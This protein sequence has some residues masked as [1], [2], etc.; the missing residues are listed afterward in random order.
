MTNGLEGLTSDKYSENM[1][2][3]RR[4]FA[5]V[6]TICVVHSQFL[7]NSE[8]QTRRVFDFL[9]LPQSGYRPSPESTKP[10][11]QQSSIERVLAAQGGNQSEMASAVREHMAKLDEF[12]A[13]EC[14]FAL[15]MCDEINAVN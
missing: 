8:Q 13:G 10:Y 5:D 3:W 4:L 14:E 2:R 7:L 1:H 11:R 15:Q 6:P 12:F 9:G